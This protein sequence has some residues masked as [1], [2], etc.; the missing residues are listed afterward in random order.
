M[1]KVWRGV[2]LLYYHTSAIRMPENALSLL[3]GQ[4]GCAST[5]EKTRQ[6][7]RM[8]VVAVTNAYGGVALVDIRTKAWLALAATHGCCCREQG[9]PWDQKG[10]TLNQ[11]HSRSLL[12]CMTAAASFF[13]CDASCWRSSHR[14]LAPAHPCEAVPEHC[15]DQW[16]AVCVKCL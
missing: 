1:S 9:H 7:Y 12:P 5:Q 16:S 6:A 4:W 8:P 14:H 10:Q 11:P 3:R 13:L 15:P 2:V